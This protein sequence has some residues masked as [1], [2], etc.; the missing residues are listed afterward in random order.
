MNVVVNN[1]PNSNTV[2][3]IAFQ[4]SLDLK[5]VTVITVIRISK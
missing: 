2:Y 3:R 4:V 5:I 1:L